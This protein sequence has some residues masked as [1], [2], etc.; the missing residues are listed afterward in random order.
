LFNEA[1]TLKQKREI[2]QD[3]FVFES[4][5]ECTFQPKINKEL[6]PSARLHRGSCVGGGKK[7]WGTS[8]SQGSTPRSGAV[9]GGYDSEGEGRGMLRSDFFEQL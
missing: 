7:G 6:T 4:D 5:A 2:I 8:Q 1:K 9:S 3:E